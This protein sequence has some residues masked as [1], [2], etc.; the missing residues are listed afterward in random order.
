MTNTRFCV[1]VLFLFAAWGAESECERAYTQEASAQDIPS[2][3]KLF[4]ERRWF[5][6]ADPPSQSTLDVKPGWSF[7]LPQAEQPLTLLRSERDELLLVSVKARI[8]F[9]RVLNRQTGNVMR[10]P[11]KFLEFGS[12]QCVTV[13]PSGRFLLGGTRTLIETPC[14]F[15]DGGTVSSYADISGDIRSVSVDS[16]G[17]TYAFGDADGDIE[18]FSEVRPAIKIDAKGLSVEKLAWMP[19]KPQLVSLAVAD[20]AIRER[21]EEEIERL[22]LLTDAKSRERRRRLTDYY[23]HEMYG[24]ETKLQIWDGHNGKAISA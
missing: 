16:K 5:G 1:F 22:E 15:E 17:K 20:F 14:P 2:G 3:A 9:L 7:R 8:P 13:L 24:R 12:A 10:G 19:G 18:V 21:L 6:K 4:R 23:W 11:A